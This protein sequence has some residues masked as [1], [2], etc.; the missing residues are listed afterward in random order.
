MRVLHCYCSIF[1]EKN[2]V[3]CAARKMLIKEASRAQHERS[4]CCKISLRASDHLFVVNHPFSFCRNGVQS[5]LWPQVMIYFSHH[6]KSVLFDRWTLEKTSERGLFLIIY[7]K[8]QDFQAKS[9]QIRTTPKNQ[10]IRAAARPTIF[11]RKLSMVER[12]NIICSVFHTWI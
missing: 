12:H 6:V 3:L 4:S 1:R 11:A 7:K 8:N 5:C 2:V 10:E 9:G